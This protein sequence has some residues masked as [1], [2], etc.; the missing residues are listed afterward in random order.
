M[1]GIFSRIS[2]MSSRLL[3]QR[4]FGVIAAS[5]LAIGLGAAVAIAAQTQ[6]FDP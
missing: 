6:I 2:A 4:K 1:A 5:A 3:G